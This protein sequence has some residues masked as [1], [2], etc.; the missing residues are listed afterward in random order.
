MLRRIPLA[1]AAMLASGVSCLAAAE[2]GAIGFA[3]AS[4]ILRA[5]CSDCHAAGAGEGGFSIDEISTRESV[6]AATDRW[7]TVRER[8]VE[9]TMPPAD[10]EPLPA[11]ERERLAEWIDDA[12][13]EAILDRGPQA[14]PP[15]LRRLARHEYANTVRDLLEVHFNA[16]EDLP[17]DGAGGEGFTNAAETL[18]ISPIH[19]EKYLAAATRALD[20]AS[21]DS[22]ARDRLLATRPGEEM[23][24][25]EAAAKNLKRLAARAYR[26]PVDD[27]EVERLVN[28]YAAARDEGLR[29]DE[30]VLYA[31]RGVLI[32]PH[33]LFILESPPSA[34]GR[35]ERLTPH[36]LA[37]RLSYFLWASMPD[38]ELR[39]AADDGSIVTPEGLREQTIRMLKHDSTHLRD[40]MGQ[41]VGQWLGTADVGAAKRID[42]E[43]HSWWEEPHAAAF[44]N[45]P[46]YVF[47]EILRDDRSILELIDAEW[48][49]LNRFLLDV[50][51][52]DR[53]EI[54]GNLRGNLNRFTL[55]GGARRRGSLLS[56]GGV[57]AVS[58]YP[59]RSSPVLR[60]VW[61]LEKILGRELPPPPPDVPELEESETA[62]T[63]MTLRERLQRHRADA[64]CAS[65]HDRIDPIG[66]TLE[67]FDEVGRWR[68]KDDGGPIDPSAT[69]PDGTQLGGLDGLKTYLLD[70][71]REFARELTRKM[72]GYAL[73]RA[74]R[75]SD[76]CTV[77]TVVGRLEG[78]GY[79]SHELILGIVESVPFRMKR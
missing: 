38:D 68:E 59:R 75:P 69:L 14:G 61:V 33:F 66:F 52:L 65:C 74:L 37:T 60:G 3:E 53:D 12:V 41:F 13:L 18:T 47:E 51:D 31:M 54:D 63:Q 67:N 64:T 56:M 58:A 35:A 42:T 16:G 39:A 19:A 5:S 76:R 48:T 21:R 36:E 34:Q 23:S 32:S 72:L 44:R 20:Y 6:D 30:A 9:R 26:R 17:E 1:C 78:S 43:K 28:V 50:Y 22:S 27:G 15:N 40:S 55:S 29:F 7:M 11:K 73:G 57:L 45:Q 2:R 70:H 10:A 71:R 8:I 62:E 46:V 49:Y 79:N 25:R 77:E 4:E 24:E